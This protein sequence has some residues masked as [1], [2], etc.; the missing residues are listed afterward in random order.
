[1]YLIDKSLEEARQNGALGDNITE[2]NVLEMQG[3]RESGLGSRGKG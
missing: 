1:M 2:S 3:M